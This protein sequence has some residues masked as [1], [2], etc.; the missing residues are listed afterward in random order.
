MTFIQPNKNNSFTNAIVLFSL[1][2]LAAAAFSLIILYNR[3]VNFEHGV[4][5]IKLQLKEIQ[6]KNIEV[7]DKIFSLIDSSKSESLSSGR[8]IQDK[9]LKY[10]EINPE[11][12]SKIPSSRVASDVSVSAR[13]GEEVPHISEGRS[14][15][16]DVR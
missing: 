2:F 7:Q 14:L 16:L 8:L 1:S 12:I 6:A 3:V 9:N 13:R 5:E 10:F 4:S 11:P 15:R